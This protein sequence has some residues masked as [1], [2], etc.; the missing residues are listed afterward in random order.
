MKRVF[1]NSLIIVA[2]AIIAAAFTSCKNRR[3]GDVKL[4]ESASVEILSINIGGTYSFGDD[5]EKEPVGSVLVYPLTEST[6]L[7]FLDVCRGA[8]SYNIGQLYGQMTIKNNIGT[9]DSRIDND[10][11]NCVLKFNFSSQQLEI[12]TD[13]EHNNCGFGFN[14]YADNT[15]KL[16]DN[17]IPEYFIN[18]EGDKTYFRVLALIPAGDD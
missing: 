10:Y 3:S 7:F 18:A 4:L 1:L 12:T 5:V 9:Y 14:V 17:S 15:Y 13:N 6:A 16:I 2:F 8:P 11:F